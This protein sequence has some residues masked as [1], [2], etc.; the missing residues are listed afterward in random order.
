MLA[1]EEDSLATLNNQVWCH[2]QQPWG[3]VIQ[4][5]VPWPQDTQVLILWLEQH[6]DMGWEARELQAMEL[7][8]H[9]CM[10]LNLAQQVL[11]LLRLVMARLQPPLQHPWLGH[12]HMLNMHRCQQHLK[13]QWRVEPSLA[14]TPLQPQI[15]LLMDW[16][17]INSKSLVMAR[18]DH[19]SRPTQA[20][21][22]IMALQLNRRTMAPHIL[23]GVE[24]SHSAGEEGMCHVVTTRTDAEVV[25]CY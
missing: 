12:L 14:W 16:V 8:S 15:T 20:A 13:E 25:L 24:E 7:I 6:M 19:L 11:E 3:E 4:V 1:M 9:Q 17:T 22:E 10:V 2:H 23:M 18:L 5:M 21:M